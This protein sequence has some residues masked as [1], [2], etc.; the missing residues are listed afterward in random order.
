MAL[1]LYHPFPKPFFRKYFSL[2][3]CVVDKRIGNKIMFYKKNY[4]IKLKDK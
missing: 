2:E 1:Q 4:N 3:N